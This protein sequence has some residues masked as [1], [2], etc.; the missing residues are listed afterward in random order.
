[1]TALISLA[2]ELTE[3]DVQWVFGAGT[4]LQIAEH[5]V[6]ISEGQ[7]VSAIHVVLE[8]L[9]GVFAADTQDQLLAR[10]GPGQIAGEMSFLEARPPTESVKALETSMVLS[11]PRS[12]LKL[13]L[14]EDVAF[15][16]RFYLGLAKSLSQR[17]RSANAHLK[18]EAPVE[19]E[20]EPVR[21]L[22][23]AAEIRKFKDLMKQVDEA[24][25]KNDGQVPAE[26]ESTVRARFQQL[27]VALNDAL[28]DRCGLNE[29]TQD[30]LG[31]RLQHELL[32]YMHLTEN[33]ERWYS[34]PRGYAGDFLTIANMYRDQPAGAGRLGPLLDRCFLDVPAAAA[35][36]NRR[37][38][39]AR[40]I[41]K[42]IEARRAEQAEVTSL[43]CGPAQELFDVYETLDDPL[44]LKATIERGVHRPQRRSP[45]PYPLARQQCSLR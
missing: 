1:M 14:D 18:A 9:L 28:G 35:V 43:A 17:L 22:P 30:E 7:P 19:R 32:P 13:K 38:I 29:R 41:R 10:L 15:A 44:K 37:G 12:A 34:K 8:G 40:E 4:E 25:L 33:A 31:I 36:R 24:A 45:P 16:S 27:V 20:A 5:T 3:S 39:L 23:I 21:W 2:S 11:V 26:L 42:T 6:L